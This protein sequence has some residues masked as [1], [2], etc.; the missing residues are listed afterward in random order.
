MDRIV[1]NICFILHVLLQ[2]LYYLLQ[3]KHV[4]QTCKMV[5]APLQNEKQN[6][7]L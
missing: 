3:S 2:Q 6:N 5:T 4:L 1:V 7:L